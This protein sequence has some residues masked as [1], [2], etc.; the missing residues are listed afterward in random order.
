MFLILRFLFGLVLFITCLSYG[1]VRTVTGKIVGEDELTPLINVSIRSIDTIQL[2]VTDI[3]GNFTVELP[4]GTNQLLL[5]A[6]AME[7]TLIKILPSCT[8]LEIIMLIDGHHDFMTLRKENRIRHRYFKN[9]EKLHLAAY[10]KR[11]FTADS[12]CFTYIFQKY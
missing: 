11:I 12:P 2:G 8:N 6:L 4:A 10:Q 1:Q 5:S 3:N 7:W 9:R